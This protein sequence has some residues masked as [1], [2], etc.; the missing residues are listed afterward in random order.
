MLAYAI[1]LLFGPYL[2]I[3]FKITI[4]FIVITSLLTPYFFAGLQNHTSKKNSVA[5]V[6]GHEL[7]SQFFSLIVLV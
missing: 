7:V 4:Y 6:A 1:L 5:I 2:Y 3:F